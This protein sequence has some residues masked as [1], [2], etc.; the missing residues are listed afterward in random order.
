MLKIGAGGDADTNNEKLQ[1]TAPWL[2]TDY[3]AFFFLMIMYYLHNFEKKTYLK[4]SILTLYYTQK[5]KTKLLE[6]NKRVFVW[7]LG[8]KESFL[9]TKKSESLNVIDTLR[10]I[11]LK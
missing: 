11:I 4:Y 6:V 3:R 7:L 10:N 2:L 5:Y 1:I 8:N 9:E